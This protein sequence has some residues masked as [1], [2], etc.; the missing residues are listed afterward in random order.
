MSD[1]LIIFDANS[2]LKLITHYTMDHEEQIPLET[3]L[4]SAGVSTMVGR[5]V[6]LEVSAKEWDDGEIDP[7]THEPPFMHVRFEGNK[8]M[9]WKQ[10]S[11]T[12]TKDSWKDAV[13]SP[14]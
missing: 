1:R 2:L 10:G 4:L 5:W 13:E 12:H 8:V 6:I 14:A 3:E 9:S 11:Q 7:V